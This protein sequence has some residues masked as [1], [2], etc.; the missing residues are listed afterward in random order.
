LDLKKEPRESGDFVD[1][2]IYAYLISFDEKE[3]IVE[4]PVEEGRRLRV[5]TDTLREEKIPA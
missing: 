5:A 3:A 4:L 2:R 1:G